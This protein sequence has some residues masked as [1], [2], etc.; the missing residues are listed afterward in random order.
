MPE[1]I[2]DDV[3]RV[4]DFGANAGFDLLYSFAPPP[5]L[6]IRQRTA[7]AAYPPAMLLK[8]VLFVYSGHITGMRN[9]MG[10]IARKASSDGHHT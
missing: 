2:L 3:K 9:S 10:R 4:F 8:V 1:E 5:A 7:L 6:R